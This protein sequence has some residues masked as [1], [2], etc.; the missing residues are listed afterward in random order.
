MYSKT[1]GFHFLLIAVGYLKQKAFPPHPETESFTS[2][3][4]ND[5]ILNAILCN[6]YDHTDENAVICDCGQ[7]ALKLTVRKEGPNQGRR[8]QFFVFALHRF[9]LV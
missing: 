4:I 5:S 8:E 3:C 1:A 6:R 9:S 2:R 7:E